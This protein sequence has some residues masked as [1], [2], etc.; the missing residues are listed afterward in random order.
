MKII[1]RE[2]FQCDHNDE[3][4]ERCTREGSR[5]V[6]QTCGLCGKDLC[7]GHYEI[8]TVTLQGTRDHFTYYFCT[9][10]TDEFIESLVEKFGDTRPLPQTGYGVTL[11]RDS[12]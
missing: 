4:G 5:D 7:A 2:L 3:D 6:I 10:H 12:H 9:N 1:E 8:T 11:N